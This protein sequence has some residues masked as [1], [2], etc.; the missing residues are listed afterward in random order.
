MPHL[1]GER[2]RPGGFSGAR[3]SEPG[4]L[5]RV[6]AMPLAIAGATCSSG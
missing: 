4:H 1:K 2:V 5:H 3:C 6:D